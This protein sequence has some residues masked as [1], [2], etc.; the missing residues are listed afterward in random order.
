[1]YCQIWKVV[2]LITRQ[3]W[4]GSK[5]RKLNAAGEIKDLT[6]VGERPWYYNGSEIGLDGIVHT[7]PFPGVNEV[8]FHSEKQGKI[9]VNYLPF[10]NTLYYKSFFWKEVNETVVVETEIGGKSHTWIWKFDE[11]PLDVT[12]TGRTDMLIQSFIHGDTVVLQY[13]NRATA[14]MNFILYNT[15]TKILEDKKTSLLHNTIWMDQNKS[16]LT[17]ILV[18]Y[19]CLLRIKARNFGNTT[20]PITSLFF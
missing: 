20:S 11:N 18:C 14:E 5:L 2:L 6:E 17:I 9:N 3:F 1:M 12:P 10:E 19:P 4:G 13:Q 7:F 8:I 15:K 16:G